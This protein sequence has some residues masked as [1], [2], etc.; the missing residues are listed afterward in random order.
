MDFKLNEYTEFL[1]W[2]EIWWVGKSLFEKMLLC[3][4]LN[5]IINKIKIVQNTLIHVNHSD[6]YHT[7]FNKPETVIH[8]SQ[9]KFVNLFQLSCFLSQIVEKQL[10]IDFRMEISDYLCYVIVHWK[11][12]YCSISLILNGF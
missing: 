7:L 6:F 3:F 10:Q 2:G 4:N 1:I 12:L 9:I 11:K 5:I 8:P